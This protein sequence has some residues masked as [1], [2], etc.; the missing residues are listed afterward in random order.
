MSQLEKRLQKF[1]R[2]PVPN[3]ITFDDVVAIATH[4]GCVVKPGGKHLK[5]SYPAFGAAV[6]IP[7]HGNLVQESYIIQLK[8]L[9]YRIE[10]EKS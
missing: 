1:Y 10:E 5:I 8:K 2:I 4:Y 6:P 9:F 3:D 7:R